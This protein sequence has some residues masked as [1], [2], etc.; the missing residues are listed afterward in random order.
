V[1]RELE[2]RRKAWSPPRMK[3]MRGVLAKYARL[4]GDA[5]HGAVTDVGGSAW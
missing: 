4:V 3:P 5:S 1:E 2:R